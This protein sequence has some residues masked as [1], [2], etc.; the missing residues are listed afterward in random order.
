MIDRKVLRKNEETVHKKSAANDR[1]RKKSAF[2]R[3][4]SNEMCTFLVLNISSLQLIPVN[5]IAYRAQY[6]S[7]SP[8]AVI[9]PGLVATLFST[10][11]AVV[12][13]KLMN[14]KRKING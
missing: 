8:T 13:C 11:V 10:I 9:G 14:R 12:F 6:G 3:V 5:V 4:A 7:A 2:G 1:E